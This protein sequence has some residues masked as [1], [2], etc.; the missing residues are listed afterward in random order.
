MTTYT[1]RVLMWMMD[2]NM[3]NLN[4]IAEQSSA[5]PHIVP[6]FRSPRWDVGM[7]ICQKVYTYPLS[8]CIHS[9]WRTS[10]RNILFYDLVFGRV[11]PLSGGRVRGF[12]PKTSP[13]A[14]RRYRYLRIYYKTGT[15]A[16]RKMRPF[17]P[18]E[19]GSRYQCCAIVRKVFILSHLP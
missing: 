5:W 12:W 15:G 19:I 13:S 11:F 14:E 18:I 4:E 6:W 7:F 3:Q 17:F 8:S 9:P 10:E 16:F 1:L 2:I